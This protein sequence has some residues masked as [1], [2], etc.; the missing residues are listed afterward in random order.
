MLSINHLHQLIRLEL[1]KALA[2]AITAAK[3]AHETATDTESIAKSKYETFA[4]EASYL[5]HG[6]SMR[7]AQCQADIRDF[8]GLFARVNASSNKEAK[9]EI[10]KLVA[11]MDDSGKTQLL[12][13]GPGAGGLKIGYEQQLIMIVT[14]ES[15]LGTAMANKWQ[16]DEFSLVVAGNKRE[17]EIIDIS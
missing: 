13:V 6:Q 4:L 2:S 12:F 17:Y 8:E 14:L 15:P 7:V 16:G 11:L 3:R 1:D 10:G 9:V 5:A